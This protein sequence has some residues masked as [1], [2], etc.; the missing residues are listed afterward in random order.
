VTCERNVDTDPRLRHGGIV[1]HD[2]VTPTGLNPGNT[3]ERHEMNRGHRARPMDPTTLPSAGVLVLRV[4]VGLTFLLHGLDKL[5]DLSSAELLFTS[6]G[7]PAPGLMAPFVGGTE[8]VGGVL[9]IAGLVTPLVGA[10]LAIDMLVALLTAH[11]G[12]GFFARDG[13]IELELLLCG[14][15]LGIGLAG[16][17]RF[18]LDG[19]L[20]LP[21]RFLQRVRAVRS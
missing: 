20:D 17:G 16:A 14:A 3:S 9:L 6:L 7:I 8:T 1:V 18:S 12:Q 19:A 13:G 21:H 10:A 5:G 15:S 4:V 2:L 11:L